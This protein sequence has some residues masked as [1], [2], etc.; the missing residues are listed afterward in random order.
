[1]SDVRSKHTSS[2]SG[3]SESDVRAFIV[4]PVG[5]SALIVVITPTPVAQ[6]LITPRK[7]M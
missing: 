1:M 3:S 2:S 4:Q 7:A 5:P 6:W